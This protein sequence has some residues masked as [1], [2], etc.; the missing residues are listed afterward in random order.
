MLF[1][2]NK[3]G[4]GLVEYA[5][6]L[7]SIAILLLVLLFL[8]GDQVVAFFSTITSEVTAVVS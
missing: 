1:L 5:M 8:L 2:P 4:Q 6:I 3:E 7:V